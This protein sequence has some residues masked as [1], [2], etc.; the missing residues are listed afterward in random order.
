[1][2]IVKG[3]IVYLRSGKDV[4]NAT[5]RLEEALR[6]T[7]KTKEDQAQ[8]QEA[9]AKMPMAEQIATANKAKGVRGKVLRILTK[10]GKVV[11]E[12]LNMITK[13]QR[14]SA[15]GGAGQVQQGGRIKME[16]AIPVS[17]VM[18][19]CPNCDKPTRVGMKQSE[20]TR[21]TLTGSKTVTRRERVCKHC[22]EV[23]PRPTERIEI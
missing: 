5:S 12:G 3:D 21:R 23:I 10:E 17:R 9:R 6:M 11:V 4:A 14:P 1:M 2:K 18:L 16:A 15:S 22:G 13:H 19:V 7:V 8:F 20:A